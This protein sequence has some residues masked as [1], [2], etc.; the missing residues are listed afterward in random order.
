MGLDA[1]EMSSGFANNK[2]ADQPGQGFS[3]RGPYK[4][5]FTAMDMQHFFGSLSLFPLSHS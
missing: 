3:R 5:A 1:K 2:E 4:S